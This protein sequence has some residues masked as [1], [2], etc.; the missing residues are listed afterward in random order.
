MRATRE[1]VG[2]ERR[3]TAWRGAI[4]PPPKRATETLS[5]W[6]TILAVDSSNMSV[7]TKYGI[8]FYVASARHV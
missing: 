4:V 7:S 8:D 5:F 2:D 6:E 1:Q 3:Y